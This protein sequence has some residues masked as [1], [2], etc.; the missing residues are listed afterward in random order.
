MS[1]SAA[2]TAHK[3]D[4]LLNYYV[5]VLHNRHS[6]MNDLSSIHLSIKPKLNYFSRAD[7]V[8]YFLSNR[9]K[10]VSII[11]IQKYSDHLSYLGN[12]S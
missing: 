2:T 10:L 12:Y 4:F 1:G 6:L 11:G 8:R 3:Y 9:H 5:L 7:S